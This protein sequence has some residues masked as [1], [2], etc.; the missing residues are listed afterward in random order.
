MTVSTD[1]L[2][3][4][5]EVK[6]FFK[7]RSAQFWK[8]SIQIKAVDG[9]SLEIMRGETLGLVGESGCGKSTLAKMI[10]GLEKPTSGGIIFND[11]N[12]ADY[13]KEKWRT[14]RQKV[15]IIFQDPYASL[16]PRR[17]AGKTI[18]EP[19]FIYG[20]RPTKAEINQHVLELLTAVGLGPEHRDRYPHEFSGGQRQRIG[21]AR[22]ISVKPELII[23]DEPVSALDVSVQ[24]QILNLLKDLQ[25]EFH[26]TYL[27]ISH[28]LGVVR[29]MSDRIAVMYLG[30]I[31]ESGTTE[32]IFKKP[33]HPYTRLLLSAILETHLPKW[34]KM[35]ED[36]TEVKAS[37]NPG[38]CLF[39]PRCPLGGDCCL[40]EE[41]VLVKIAE[42]HAVACH[43]GN[44]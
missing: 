20:K 6:K 4:T 39:Y 10:L 11:E 17:T 1:I 36:T 38:M 9:V 21:I 16:N 30:R 35:V 23:A 33:R 5:K 41:P 34:E 19:F 28:N 24:A 37:G 7:S 26:L 44:N 31:V 15:Q 12:I 42:E 27:F 18:G 13:S 25:E 8:Q 22:A 3:S 32:A 29:H 2:L 14:F 40:R 43:F